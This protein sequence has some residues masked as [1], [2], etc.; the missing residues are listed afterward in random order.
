MWVETAALQLERHCHH[1]GGSKEIP[2]KTLDFREPVQNQKS[3]ATLI[4]E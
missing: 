2:E 1:S 4:P 3:P